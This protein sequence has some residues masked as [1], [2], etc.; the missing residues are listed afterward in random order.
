MNAPEAIKF[1]NVFLVATLFIGCM[2]EGH[3]AE[4][5]VARLPFY[6]RYYDLS[7]PTDPL[8]EAVLANDEPGIDDLL[9]GV[10]HLGN[11]ERYRTTPLHVAV[12]LNRTN[13]VKKLL[14]AGADAGVCDWSGYNVLSRAAQE[15]SV[16]S[17]ALILRAGFSPD[18]PN[19]EGHGCPR[20][21]MI[22]V[23]RPVDGRLF[24][25][26]SAERLPSYTREQEIYLKIITL[27]AE[28][29]AD[30]TFSN[31]FYGSYVQCAGF[32]R[33]YAAVTLIQKL[34]E[35]QKLQVPR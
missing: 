5:S 31:R 3:F 27:L 26:I 34:Q 18:L 2:H 20:P 14:S 4:H 6:Y 29:G 7:K 21:L 32:S 13:I 9:K 17:V 10:V 33:N 12:A 24:A 8:M 30:L 22:A 35:E 23:G 1:T 28:A 11:V 15:A 16:E 19:L 25:R